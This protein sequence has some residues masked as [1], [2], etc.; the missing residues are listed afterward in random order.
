MAKSPVVLIIR[1]GW[2]VNPGGQET[3]EK[4]GN[5]SLLANT[6]FHDVMLEQYPKGFVSASGLDVGLPDGQMG[7][8]EVGHLNLGAGRVVYQDLTRINKAIVDNELPSNKVLQET[9]AK[10][11]GKRLHLIGLVSDGGVHS[12]QDHI[13]AL[14]AA[15]KE[16]GVEDIMLHAITDGRDTSPTGGA[17]Y[18]STVED[19][20]AQHGTRIATVIG[21]Y[22]AMDRDKRWERT[23][24]AWDAIVLGK[25][26]E[27]SVLA[28]EA[29]AEQYAQADKTDE[30]LP[31][32]IFGD[33]NTQRVRDGDVILVFN[34]RAD[35]VRQISQAF[36]NPDFDGFDTV[37]KP[38]AHYVT[39]T[40]YDETYGVPIVFP[41]IPL[42]KVLGEVVSAAGKQQ[43]RIAETEKYPH[44]TYFFNGG[45]EKQFEGEDRF[46][47]PS[48]KDVPTYDHKPEMS[49][50]E[51]TATVVEKLKDYDLVILNFANPDM[52]GHTGVVEA[53]IKA[54]ET[55]DGSVK[56]VVEETLRLGGK[57]LITADHG[58]CEFMRNADGSPHTAHTTNLVHAVYVAADAGTKTVRDGILADIAPTLLEMLGVEQP[59]EMTGKSLVEG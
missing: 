24:L 56:E 22:Y 31:P 55:I 28:S 17:D 48:P 35:R 4:D 36:L 8:S 40:E 11:S 43:M 2:G 25:G 50:A 41:S 26:E 27:K 29:V 9:F 44:V 34:F 45:V 1:D 58:N 57:L 5:A 33:A 13:V 42:A 49:A 19:Q 14:A 3:A 53:A 37:V 32:M 30:F 18:L 21:R 15:A 39:L 47:I 16:A 6:P 20:L 23:K 51:V 10:A 52:V 7:N 54:V 46:I 59:A 38:Q 12:H